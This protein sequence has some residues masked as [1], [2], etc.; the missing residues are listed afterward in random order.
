[1]PDHSSRTPIHWI[2]VP[3]K[4]TVVFAPASTANS[5]VPPLVRVS[6]LMNQGPTKATALLSCSIRVMPPGR[7]TGLPVGS[8]A[9]LLVPLAAPFPG[10]STASTHIQEPPERALFVPVTSMVSECVPAA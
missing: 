5:A 8:G 3:V 9:P 10:T 4:V 7:G 6:P 2:H 1:M